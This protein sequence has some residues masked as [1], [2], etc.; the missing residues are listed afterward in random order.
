V[1]SEATNSESSYDH[2]K[3]EYTIE[4]SPTAPEWSSGPGK[5][6]GVNFEEDSDLVSGDKKPLAYAFPLSCQ[7]S[8][9]P[10]GPKNKTMGREKLPGIGPRRLE[11]PAQAAAR[12]QR[13]ASRG[14]ELMEV[15][16]N[17]G[18]GEIIHRERNS[19]VAASGPPRVRRERNVREREE[20]GTDNSAT[21]SAVSA[22]QQSLLGSLDQVPSAQ[23]WG[24]GFRA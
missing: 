7:N 8:L 4:G 13:E 1:R 2:T 17:A 19:G 23:I 24:L 12:A 21:S 18:L 3:G 10:P 14:V 20:A 22:L 15:Y 6:A 9:L 16:S 5:E 11:T